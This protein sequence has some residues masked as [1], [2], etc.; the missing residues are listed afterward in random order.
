M[1]MHGLY[2]PQIYSVGIPLRIYIRTLRNMSSFE[3]K[4]TIFITNCTPRDKER[5]RFC[6]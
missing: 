2:K 6:S 5:T 1:K 4:S 3:K